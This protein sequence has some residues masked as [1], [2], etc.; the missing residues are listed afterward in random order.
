LDLHLDPCSHRPSLAPL[1]RFVAR[2]SPASSPGRVR[3]GSA[4]RSSRI[5]SRFGHHV[6][7]ILRRDRDATA[8]RL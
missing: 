3:R 1:F 6:A 2:S 5:S 4:T 8:T 7:V